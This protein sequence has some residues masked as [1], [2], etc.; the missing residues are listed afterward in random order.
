MWYTGLPWASIPHYY[1][2]PSGKS[3]HAW[4]PSPIDVC[5]SILWYWPYVLQ[6]PTSGDGSAASLLE[7]GVWA[8][9]AKVSVITSFRPNVHSCNSVHFWC[10]SCWCF[11]VRVEAFC[12]GMGTAIGELPPY[13]MARAARLSGGN[14]YYYIVSHS[15]FSVQCAMLRKEN[16]ANF[17]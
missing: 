10:T 3:G 2:V 13:F 9:I 5:H 4:R 11:Q 17:Q 7:V 12:W 15:F 14:C 1:S 6:Q 8:I 16:F